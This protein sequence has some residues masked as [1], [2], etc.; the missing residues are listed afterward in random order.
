MKDFR[1]MSAIE[2][3]VQKIYRPK[4]TALVQKKLHCVC[5]LVSFAK[6]KITVLHDR[7]LTDRVLDKV[8]AGRVFDELNR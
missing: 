1:K 2:K 5:L 4:N 6:S 7:S 3:V 8:S